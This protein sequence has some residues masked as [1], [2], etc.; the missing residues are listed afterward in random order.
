MGET[1]DL[2]L[3]RGLKL[4]RIITAT[5]AGMFFFIVLVQMF[6]FPSIKITFETGNDAQQLASI[7]VKKGTVVDL[8]IPLKP[9]SCFMGWS[10]SPYS[11]EVIEDAV[12]FVENTTLYAV[13]DG[14]EKYAILS[15]NGVKHKEVNIFDTSIEGLT[16]SQLNA[17]WRVLDDFATDNSNRIPFTISSTKKV[18]VDPRNNF[19]RFLGWQYLNSYGVYND[20]LYEPDAT[21]SAGKWTLVERDNN[22]NETK[23]EITE[24]NKFYPPNYRTTFSALLEYR[25]LDIQFFDKDASRHDV[26][27]RIPLGEKNI[28][29][30]AYKNK[31]NPDA[32]FSHWEL[33]VG[34]IK[35]NYVDANKQPELIEL[36]KNLKTR[37]EAG[38][39]INTLDPLW[40]YLGTGL[41]S[42]DGLSDN[43]V[44]T[45]TVRAVY[46]D[47]ENV[48][49]FSVQPYTDLHSG[50]EYRDFSDVNFIDLSLQNPVSLEDNSVWLYYD[51]E[52]LSYSFY[53]HNGK[54]H[55]FLSSTLK[56]NPNTGFSIGVETVF[57]GEQI[58]FNQNW[59]IT[60]RV[61]YRSSAENIS[62][63]FNYGSD[64]Y[65]LPN[66]RHYEKPIITT[67]TR[68]IGNS[69]VLLTGENYLKT[70]HIFTGWRLVGDESER[71]YCA[72]E[73]FTIPNFDT[74]KESTVFEFQAV[75]HLQRLL[76]DF[77]FMGGSWEN[78]V[79]PN[80][81]LMKGAYS[82]RI[83]II[84][85]IPVRFGYDFVG[86]TLEKDSYTDE[87]EL[88]QPGDKINV[89]TKIQ[90][91]YAHWKP[92]KLRVLFYTR[93]INGN[94][95]LAVNPVIQDYNGGRLYSGGYVKLPYIQNTNWSTFNGWQVGEQTFA[96][97]SELQLTTAVLSQLQ[98]INVED[99][100]IKN[101]YILEVNLFANQTKH[102][103]DLT[104]D[105][106]VVIS[107]LETVSIK[108]DSTKLDQ[109]L[110]QG[111]LFYDYYPFSEAKTN[112]S[113]AAF[114]TNGRR[115]IGW[116]YSINNGRDFI[117]I[118]ATTRV[119]VGER[120]IMIC[121]HL[122]EVKSISV[123]YHKFTGESYKVDERTYTY[124]AVIPLLDRNSLGSIPVIDEEL[125]S[126]VGWGLEQ[127]HI[128]GNPEI[129]YDA[130]YIDNPLLQLGNKVD[131]TISDTTPYFIDVDHYAI[132]TGEN[133][134][135]LNFYPVYSTDHVTVTYDHYSTDQDGN[136]I[137]KELKFPV[138]TNGD[139]SKTTFGGSTVG[140]ESP[141]FLDYGY[142]VLDDSTLPMYSSRNFIGWQAMVS[143]GVSQEV[144]DYFENKIWLPGEFMPVIDFN[145]EFLP[146]RC[147]QNK[148]VQEVTVGNRTYRVLS[149]SNGASKINFNG[150]VDIVA[151]PGGNYTITEGNVNINSDRE[152]HIIIPANNESEIVLEPRAIQANTIKEFYVGENLTVTGSP[153]IGANFAAYRVQ[154]GY[155][156]IDETGNPTG[157]FYAS[158]KYDYEASMFGLLISNDCETLYAVPST[159]EMTADELF[160]F[161]S[162]KEIKRIK[163]YAL[164]DLNNKPI[165]NLGFDLSDNREMHIEPYAI[166]NGS[167][168]HVILP[169]SSDSNQLDISAQVLSGALR[170]LKTVTFGDATNTQSCYAFV[171]NGFVYY[172]D[173]P[174]LP[175]ATTHVMYVL[176]SAKLESLAYTTRNL[177]FDDSVTMIEPYALMGRDW[178]QINSIMAENNHVNVSLLVGIPNNIPIFISKENDYKDE[179]K[180]NP[181]IQPYEKTFVFTYH[182]SISGFVEE[183]LNFSYG[184]TFTVFNAQ[185]NN[186]HFYFD[187]LWAQFVGWKLNGSTKFFNIGEVYKVGIS[188]AIL[189]DK[190]TLYFNA[191][192][193]ECWTSYPVQFY[194][195]DGKTNTP[196]TPEVFYDTEGGK[197]SIFDL[198]K[199]YHYLGD[200][201]LPG[202]DHS[203]T[204][205]GSVYQFVGWGTSQTNPNIFSSLLWNNVDLEYRILPNQTVNTGLNTGFA[206]R[207]NGTAVY[208]Y[209]ALYEKV[210]PEIQYE[211][212]NDNTAYAVKGMTQTNVTSLN[213]PFARYHNGYMLPVIKIN[214]RVFESITYNTSL[215]EISI[216]G[217]IS[218]IGDSAFSGVNANQI[219]FAHK[220]RGIYYNYGQVEPMRQLTVGAEAFARN[221]NI[222]KIVLPASLKT[223]NDRAF[224]S[225]TS[226][227]DLTFES[228]ITPALGYIGDFV[229]RDNNSMTNNEIVRLLMEDGKKGTIRFDY[230]DVGD[231]IFMNTSIANVKTSDGQ[232]TNKIVWRDTLLHV[233]YPNG[234]E[235]NLTFDEK[236]IAGYAFVNAGSDT[237][238][239]VEI[240][241]RFT[242]ANTVIHA[243]AFSNLHPSVKY[244][245]LKKD[246]KIAI[247]I[248][249]VDLNAFDD[250]VKHTVNVYTS[251]MVLWTE[252]FEKIQKLGYF[253]FS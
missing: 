36:L 239:N 98:S 21:G 247:N 19:T 205:D 203:F 50:T 198:L 44:V 156:V 158:N 52:I 184:Q 109:V 35:N 82:N 241:I 252:K 67:Y 229:F 200:I 167:V 39:V 216:G 169:Q 8:P 47:D 145:I 149:L 2:Q 215:T 121:G 174:S 248:D 185:K 172:I 232:T 103:A 218:E 223:L 74:E 4:T 154:K 93:D 130:Y 95:S 163:S 206:E 99:P 233:Y 101:S 251:N 113:Y 212:I 157:I 189:G 135:E 236:E 13:W 58:Y 18:M 30:P 193:N 56:N 104:Y 45:L 1:K 73:W 122:A 102:T 155:R 26:S 105:L 148:D 80:F 40:Y 57:L 128:S 23:S 171:E 68:K 161:L 226:L 123:V 16:A 71:L 108:V 230:G 245:H 15:V 140:P 118:D 246:N 231:G 79:A 213:I 160:D 190:Y 24:T 209:Y 83:Q 199:Y 106:D 119:P 7:S 202:I 147:A 222:K 11:G 228:G 49:H 210:T 96:A 33:Q 60:I 38:E 175:G 87:S 84:K 59:A 176:P 6:L 111:D 88:L 144:K 238:E 124:G 187:K 191:A 70:D 166:F 192:A 227:V 65:T 85:D 221:H 32:H 197:Y 142:A 214:E 139:Y 208:K 42:P 173:N 77:N 136:V 43:L 62:V 86:W 63:K 75:W 240:T 12:E 34:E 249:N 243:N 244:I 242:N 10:L 196:Y 5:M 170:N 3:H 20:L 127:D 152:V 234:F 211:L 53:D 165:I 134:Y 125:G 207:E 168:S 22:G 133:S 110:V 115:F 55:E 159:V 91:L 151:F 89:G 150:S 194:I 250:T 204:K 14:A 143:D 48:H 97:N 46:W 164:S 141:D 146:I 253:R 162:A 112:G 183:R 129:I 81:A 54:Y 28:V 94:P 178:S 116:S 177:R 225:C 29:M 90:T 51:P 182:N 107:N 132:R 138:F 66:Y 217:A 117:P 27:M 153:V 72:G 31:N 201:Y 25:T 78:D 126:F 69:F 37:Y 61:N 179:Y 220:G 224:Q 237:D 92:R 114:D 188:D 9:G 131:T 219:N 137:N 180:T 195:S 100:E 41:I 64:L 181:M 235:R 120:K 76:F 17:D 186:Y